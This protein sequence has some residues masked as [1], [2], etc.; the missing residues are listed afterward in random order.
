MNS[1]YF[2]D[3]SFKILRGRKV[4]YTGQGCVGILSGIIK[5][6]WKG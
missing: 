2:I 6:F 3:H 5:A 4:M 1:N